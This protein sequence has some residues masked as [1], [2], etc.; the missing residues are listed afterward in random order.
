MRF[1]V[2]AGQK[3]TLL[4]LALPPLNRQ[5]LNYMLARAA[6]LCTTFYLAAFL[7]FLHRRWILGAVLHLLALETKAI[8][9][10][11]PVMIVVQDFLYRDRVRYPTVMSYIRDWRRLFL[12]VGILVVLNVAYLVQRSILL[13][14]WAEAMLHERW[15][16]PWIWFMNQ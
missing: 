5:A 2:P 4:F 13:P 11:L 3:F 9:V 16:T 1:G 15:V 14:E 12:P 8:A 6:L 10:T 7:G